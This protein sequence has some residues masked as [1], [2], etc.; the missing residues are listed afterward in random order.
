MLAL[1]QVPKIRLNDIKVQ[2]LGGI[3]NASA[4]SICGC[5][6]SFAITGIELSE[7]STQCRKLKPGYLTIYVAREGVLLS[8]R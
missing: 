3:E 2:M 1:K 6:F 7:N 5:P 8:D 4:N